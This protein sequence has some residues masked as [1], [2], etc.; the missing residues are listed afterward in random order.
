MPTPLN[1]ARRSGT[2]FI[3]LAIGSLALLIG[4]ASIGSASPFAHTATALIDTILRAG[5]PAVLYLL[6][7]IGLGRVFSPF[8]R[9]A[10]DPLAL[11]AG[12]GLAL[13]LSL[14]HGLGCLGLLRGAMGRGIAAGVVAV[15]AALLVRQLVRWWRTPGRTPVAI[16][17]AAL[18]GLPAA[19]LLLVAACQP[20]G[21]LWVSEFGAYDVLSYHL[22]LPREWLALGRITPLQHNVYSYLPGYVEAAFLHLSVLIGAR[23]DAVPGDRFG[24]LIAGEGMPLIACQFLHAF[25]AL[26]S[27]WLVTRCVRAA[28]RNAGMGPAT[29]TSAS[30]FAGVTF[31]S[32]SWIIVTASLAYDEMG[33]CALGGAALCSAMDTNLSPARRG[34]VTGLLVGVACGCKAT[35]LPFVGLPAGVL[36]LGLAMPRNWLPIV[37]A[38]CVAGLLALSPWLIRNAAAGGNPVFPY[39]TGVLG[40][41]H[42]TSEQATR[43]REATTFDGSLADRLSL[44]FIKDANDPA[45]RRHRG[46]LHHQWGVF[47]PVCAISLG[48]VLALRGTRRLGVLL[49]A[50]LLL[51]LLAWLFASHLQSRFLIP[52]ALPGCIA[53]GIAAAHA[54]PLPV[55]ADLIMMA[56]VVG[57]Q[58]G[59]S[60]FVFWREHRENPNGAL[61][62]GPGLYTGAIYRD[63]VE[64]EKIVAP[65]PE[66][67][68]NLG[69]HRTGRLLL[70]GDATPLYFAGPVEYATTWDRSPLAEMIDRAPDKPSAWTAELRGQ[71]IGLV[72][73]NFAELQRLRRSRFLDPALDP[74]R[75]RNW[76]ET[77]G[78]PIRE[79]PG[80]RALFALPTETTR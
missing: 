59:M 51:Q 35:A 48:V 11:Q 40:T 55:R 5:A 24:G 52:L 77:L 43:F 29:H 49:G 76:V 3:G 7:A 22:Q 42:W 46:M 1:V 56:A 17:P 16:P 41:A 27:A 45:G 71:G 8:I 72:L 19:A 36:L 79:W 20:P 75:V 4:L 64:A 62:A 50:A 39:L 6:A 9:G 80:G 15:G 54:R 66:I 57:V 70:V 65:S 37:L 28:L 69:P 38:G 53:I 63:L 12:L 10:A 13:M 60:L 2:A 73:V 33:V 21:W 30:A 47:F 78:R 14:S 23:P 61:V 25:L 18:L 74:E 68:L 58:F 31:L 26:L 67:F 34:A 44:L 32:T